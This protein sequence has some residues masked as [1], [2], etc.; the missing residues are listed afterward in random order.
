[1][2]IYEELQEL[3]QD[4]EREKRNPTY[5][6]AEREYYAG[7]AHAYREVRELYD[8]RDKPEPVNGFYVAEAVADFLP[9]ERKK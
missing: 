7:M 5:S 1:M 2:T 6:L 9:P 4:A 3:E 8:K